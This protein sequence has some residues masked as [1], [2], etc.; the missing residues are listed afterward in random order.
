M[1]LLVPPQSLS[2]IS[3][4][5]GFFSFAAAF[6]TRTRV[7]AVHC[8]FGHCCTYIFPHTFDPRPFPLSQCTHPHGRTDGRTI[9]R[10]DED[11]DEDDD[12]NN[13][14]CTTGRRT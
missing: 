13:D 7:Q 5:E 2:R 9:V 1:V 4:P 11:E 10:D 14:D 12:N 6:Q 3:S 8:L